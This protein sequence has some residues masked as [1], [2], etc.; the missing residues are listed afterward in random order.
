MKMHYAHALSA[1]RIAQIVGL[2]V[3]IPVLGLVVVGIFMAKAEHLFEEKYVLHASLKQSYGLEP[4]A[5][6]LVSG[7]PIGR[8]MA[9]EF[10][11]HGT[12]TVTLL[13]LTKYQDKV[14]EDSAASIVKSGLIMG[15]AQ[16][17]IAMG[18]RSKPALANGATI[19]TIEPRD[20]AELVKDVKPVLES[21]QRTLLRV[22][23]ITKDVHTTVQAGT[24][25]L[26]NVE[27]AT[28]E[29]P[30]VVA[31]VQRA[32]GSVERTTAALPDLTGSVQRTLAMAEGATGDVRAATRKLPAV[33]DAAQ[34]AVNN[35]KVTTQSLKG[36]AKE[37]PPL[38]RTAH[39]T[40]DDVNLIARGAKHTFPVSVFVKNAEPEAAGR[41]ENGLRSLRGDL[42]GR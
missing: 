41:S 6:V 29:L 30:G 5:S 3:I 22:E 2:F 8:V 14:R 10:D 35:I 23:E 33:V 26:T 20:L 17:E 40:L 11:D 36:I 16:V 39:A 13:L 4:G 24:H 1:A 34:D 7:I 12:I 19:Q 15:Q 27:Q 31:S 18:N 25:V 37:I 9:V 32:V 42:L 21:V 38:M 28:R